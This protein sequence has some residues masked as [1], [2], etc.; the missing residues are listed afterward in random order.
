MGDTQKHYFFTSQFLLNGLHYMVSQT[1]EL[2]LN[3]S[4]NGAPHDRVLIVKHEDDGTNNQKWKSKMHIVDE[5]IFWTLKTKK[6]F[7]HSTHSRMT[8]DNCTVWRSQYTWVKS[9]GNSLLTPN[10]MPNITVNDKMLNI[11]VTKLDIDCFSIIVALPDK[12]G[13]DCPSGNTKLFL[14]LKRAIL[15]QTKMWRLKLKV[16]TIGVVQFSLRG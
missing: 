13:L 2:I 8:P 7:L 14:A 10:I 4:A 9:E 6:I 11:F 12:T 1:R 3:F 5:Q 15:N 16:S